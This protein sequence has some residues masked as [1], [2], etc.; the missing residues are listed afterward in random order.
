M[1]PKNRRKFAD[2]TLDELDITSELP[3]EEQLTAESVD[4]DVE[5]VKEE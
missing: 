2:D 1:L 3:V 5:I 4:K